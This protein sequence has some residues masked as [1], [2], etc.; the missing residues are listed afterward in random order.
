MPSSPF[1]IIK[2]PSFDAANSRALD[3]VRGFVYTTFGMCTDF[4]I[5]EDVHAPKEDKTGNGKGA[6]PSL[7]VEIVDE[8]FEEVYE[9]LFKG[10]GLDV[11]ERHGGKKGGWN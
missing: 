7:D 6:G 5:M 4:E 8:P 11:Y 2:R 3:R 9:G 10:W 1:Q